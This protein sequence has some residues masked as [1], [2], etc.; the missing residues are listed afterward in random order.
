PEARIQAILLLGYIY[1][2]EGRALALAAEVTERYESLVAAT[3]ALADEGRPVVL[4]ATD[5]SDSLWAAGNGSTEAGILEAAGGIC[6]PCTA[7]VERN[8][9]ISLESIVAMNPDV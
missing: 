4:Y 6:A 5:Y 1:G 8:A 3:G 2:E 9:A 7:G